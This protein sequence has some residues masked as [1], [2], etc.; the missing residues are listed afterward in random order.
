MRCVRSADTGIAGRNVLVGTCSSGRDACV[1]CAL[2]TICIGHMRM[3]CGLTLGLLLKLSFEHALALS[4]TLGYALAL[5]L[6]LM[7]KYN[8]YYSGNHCKYYK[9]YKHGTQSGRYG[10]ADLA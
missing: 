6:F 7:V 1:A 8:E 3:H 2:P 10:A 5:F 9:H 4:S